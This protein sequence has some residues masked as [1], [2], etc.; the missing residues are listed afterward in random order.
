MECLTKMMGEGTGGRGSA[1]RRWLEPKNCILYPLFQDWQ[2]NP[3]E[4]VEP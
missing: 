1:V 2:K 4:L 3:E